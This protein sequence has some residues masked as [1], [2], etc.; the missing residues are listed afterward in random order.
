MHV[1]RPVVAVCGGI[2]DKYYCEKGRKESRL[3]AARETTKGLLDDATETEQQK[4]YGAWTEYVP[5][6]V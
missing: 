3:V 4:E 6:L 1:G 5:A 2:R